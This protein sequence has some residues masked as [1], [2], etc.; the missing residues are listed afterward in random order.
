MR[1]CSISSGS[2]GNCFLV[3]SDRTNILIDVGVSKKT[4]INAINSINITSNMISGILI[5][6]EHIDHYKGASVICKGLGIPIYLNERTFSSIQ[7]KLKGVNNVNIIDKMEFSIG[8]LDI[9]AFKLPHDAVDPIGYS[10]LC[11]KKKLSVVT[12]IGHISN[13]IFNNIRDSDVVLLESN[14]NEEMLR[15]SNYPHF[16]KE[17]ILSD[18][19]HLSNEECALTI[20]KLVNISYKRIILGHLSITSNFPELAYK[21][22]ERILINHGMKIGEDLKLTVAHRSLPSN[23]MRF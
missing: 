10:V 14:Y 22:S 13:D 23:Y 8:D 4:L 21:T 2:S 12:D 7:D 1:F 17:R 18:N 15:L 19:G 20:V 6:H 3:G 9:K 16:L 5:T 11:K